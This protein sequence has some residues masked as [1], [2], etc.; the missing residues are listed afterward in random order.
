MQME[1]SIVELE[2]RITH[3]EKFIDELNEVAIDQGKMIDRL[4]RELD[5][6]KEKSQSSPVD[7]SHPADER[8]PHY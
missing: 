6:L 2:K 5:D 1:Q 4:K 3:L 8:P 7:P